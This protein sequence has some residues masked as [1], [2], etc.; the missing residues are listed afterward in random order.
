M[1]KG[2]GSRQQQPREGQDGKGDFLQ[3]GMH[4]RVIQPVTEQR[5]PAS[6]TEKALPHLGSLSLGGALFP[7]EPPLND[8][9]R[10]HSALLCTDQDPLL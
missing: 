2:Q 10:C 6:I 1:R 3:V 4:A 9:D 7:L 5:L 8:V